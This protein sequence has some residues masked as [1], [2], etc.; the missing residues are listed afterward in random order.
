MV[1]EVVRDIFV[2]LAVAMENLGDNVR[3]GVRLVMEVAV[4][5]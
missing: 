4:V 1:G 2:A 5:L 3:L